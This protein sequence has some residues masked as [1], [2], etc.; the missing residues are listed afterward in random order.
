MRQWTAFS[1]QSNSWLQ[2]HHI[3]SPRSLSDIQVLDIQQMKSSSPFQNIHSLARTEFLQLL[4]SKEASNAIEIWRQ[5]KI[6]ESQRRVGR[7]SWPTIVRAKSHVT[8]RVE[9]S[10][11]QP[12][13]QLDFY[14]IICNKLPDI[15]GFGWIPRI[16]FPILLFMAK[17]NEHEVAFV[18]QHWIISWFHYSITVCIRINYK[19]N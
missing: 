15:A 8:K 16:L 6:L 1:L 13:Q 17:Y 2:I 18:R 3:T 9:I 5:G 14:W 12:R 19:N 11:G 10:S 7:L 4:D